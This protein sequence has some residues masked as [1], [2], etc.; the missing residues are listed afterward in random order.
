MSRCFGAI[1]TAL[2]RA[3]PTD[4][5]A[6]RGG[7]LVFGRQTAGMGLSISFQFQKAVELTSTVRDN[8]N[9]SSNTVIFVERIRI[10]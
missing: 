8:Y 10:D 5:H 9:V 3:L 2:G 6:T 7:N 1:F 4:D